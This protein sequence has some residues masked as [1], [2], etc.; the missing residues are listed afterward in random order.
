MGQVQDNT[1]DYI[2]GNFTFIQKSGL[3][4]H[5]TLIL[6]ETKRENSGKNQGYQSKSLWRSCESGPV[7]PV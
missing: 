6:I 3:I 2:A 5:Q 7:F 1:A 4:P